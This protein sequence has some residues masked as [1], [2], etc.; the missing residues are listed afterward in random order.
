MSRAFLL[1]R[2]QPLYRRD[3][4]ASGLRRVGYEVHTHVPTAPRSTDVLCIWNRYGR[5]EHQ[6]R[7]FENVGGRVLV[8]ENGYLGRDWR[9]QHW[10]ALSLSQHN[11]AGHWNPGGPERWDRLNAELADWRENGDE[12][13]VLATRHIGPKEV[14][15]PKGWSQEVASKLRARVRAHPGEKSCVPLADDLSRARCVVTWGSGGALK[16]LAMGIPVQYGFKRWIGAQGGTPIGGNGRGERLA[17]FRRLA[18]AM[19]TTEELATGE[20]FARLLA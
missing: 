17:M 10:Y 19:W 13:V 18:W 7:Y 9:G 8:A 3:A 6:A 15:E 20:P 5:N 11:G 12:T 16:A 1:I 2:D 4:F 14:A